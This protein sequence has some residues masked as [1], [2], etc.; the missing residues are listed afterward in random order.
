MSLYFIANIYIQIQISIYIYLSICN[1][2]IQILCVY[3]YVYTAIVFGFIIKL[4]HIIYRL[5]NV[6]K[7]K[8]ENKF[9]P[10]S[11]KTNNNTL[12]SYFCVL[13][14]TQLRSYCTYMCLH[15]NFS[16]LIILILL[17]IFYYSFPVLF[18]FQVI[19]T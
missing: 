8:T 19:E 14:F 7:Y 6:R 16:L 5:E 3:I 10:Y 1:I 15:L 18:C 11:E 4:L 13:V 2:Y 12:T 9:H 17:I